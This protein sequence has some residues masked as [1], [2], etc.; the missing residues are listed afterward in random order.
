MRDAAYHS[1]APRP[2]RQ[3]RWSEAELTALKAAHPLE[4]IAAQYRLALVTSGARLVA[5]CPFH[6]ERH[7]S[8]TIFPES[9][10]WWCFGCQRGGDVIEFVRLLEG[11]GFREAVERLGGNPPTPVINAQRLTRPTAQVSAAGRPLVARWTPGGQRAMDVA[12]TCYMRELAESPLARRYLQARG[13]S[14]ALVRAASLGYCS[15]ER[16]HDALR[17]ER[18]PL[19]AGWAV[20][21]LAGRE[22]R[23]RFSGRI[24]IPEVRNGH[25][26]WLTSRLLDDDTDAPRYLSLPGPRPLYGAERVRGQ[27]AVIGVEGYFDA[28]TLWGWGLPAFAAGGVSLPAD[29]LETLRAARMIFLAFD[30][31]APGQEAARVLTRQLGTRLR[32]VSL[33]NG[34][35]DVNELGL[36]HDGER[37]FRACIQRAAQIER[38]EQEAA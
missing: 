22:G 10:R 16:L 33:P 24:T 13:L 34:V 20:G 11:F 1:S 6:E 23:E 4:A 2:E 26:R 19:R 38:A 18:I 15:G 7:P 31:D 35:K 30:Q 21:L 28:L 37:Q 17:R 25:A 14:E 5:L 12:V 9:Q 3:P 27:P 32:H 8:F 36:Q 29:A